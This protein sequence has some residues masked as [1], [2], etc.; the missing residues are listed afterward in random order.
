MRE[1]EG[2]RGRGYINDAKLPPFRNWVDVFN[3]LVRESESNRTYEQKLES[4][5]HYRSSIQ[6]P[7]ASSVTT[8]SI[9]QP[10]KTAMSQLKYFNYP[11]F[12]ENM[13][14]I[15]SQAVRIGDRVE[16]SGQGE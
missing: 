6:P 14:H 16:L 13:A 9:N 4:V 15:Y 5:L 1:G 2:R 12:G 7:S 11:G 3:L 10:F 8:T